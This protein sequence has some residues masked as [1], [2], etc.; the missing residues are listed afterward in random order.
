MARSAWRNNRCGLLLCI[1]ECLLFYIQ[2]VAK[3]FNK[4]AMVYVAL[5]SI[6]VCL[7]NDLDLIERQIP[8]PFLVSFSMDMIT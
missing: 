1:V 2:R 7:E 6:F 8:H 4:W 5:V 3:Y